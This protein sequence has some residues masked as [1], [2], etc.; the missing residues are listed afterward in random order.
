VSPPK[1]SNKL[2]KVIV[3]ENPKATK[4]LFYFASYRFSWRIYWLPVLRLRNRGYEVVV[5]DIDDFV[6]E[7]HDPKTLPRAAKELIYDVKTR[8]NEYKNKGINTYHGVGNS[9]GSYLLF[10]CALRVP[11][12]AIV[13]NGSGSVADVIFSVKKG[14][15]KKT[16][17]Q[18]KLA[19]IDLEKLSDLWKEYD[20][21][22]LG[23]G[24]KA[25]RILI[26]WSTKDGLVP[27]NSSR[28]FIKSIKSSGKK[29]VV[30]EDTLPH[31]GSIFLNSHNVKFLYQFLNAE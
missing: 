17:E 2:F 5:Y 6:V 23:K 26:T 27:T 19:S 9:L 31:V 8:Q 18:Y 15:L 20:K 11:F 3:K 16:A 30:K 21:P 7:S 13:L 29:V 4:V 10:N 14:P 25:N 22:D 12:D 1:T 24:I 28:D